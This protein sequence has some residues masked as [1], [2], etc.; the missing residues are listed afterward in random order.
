[1]AEQIIQFR[2][3]QK[4]F[5][6]TVVYDDLTLDVRRG[7]TLTIIGGSG[8]GKSVCLKMLLAS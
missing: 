5:K 3:V 4:A 1:M 2:G 6:G 7:E 8:V